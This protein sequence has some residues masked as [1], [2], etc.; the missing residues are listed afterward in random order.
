MENTSNE[1]DT[2]LDPIEQEWGDWTFWETFEVVAIDE[3]DRVS[4]NLPSF[5]TL[6]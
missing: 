2:R 4:V 6:R 3:I 1:K 5:R